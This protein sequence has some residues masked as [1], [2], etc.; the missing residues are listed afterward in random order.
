MPLGDLLLSLVTRVATNN[1]L[2]PLGIIISWLAYRKFAA[3]RVTPALRSGV[4]GRSG[5]LYGAEITA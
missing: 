5:C 1:L 3:P 4:Q 2:Q